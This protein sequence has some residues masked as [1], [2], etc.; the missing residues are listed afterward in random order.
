MIDYL[1]A[2]T[3]MVDCQLR[4]NGVTDLAV[5]EAF[6]TVPREEFVPSRS[7]ALSYTDEDIAVQP[8][9]TG[10]SAR[11]LMAPMALA[12]LISL[13]GIE[14]DD[15]VLDIG[16]ASGYSTALLSLLCN[17]V[18]A[19]ECDEDLA[20][21]AGEKLTELNYDNAVV[22]SGALEDG[23][24]SEG[25]YDI[26]FI[27]GAVDRVPEALFSQLKDGGRLAV[28]EGVGNAGVARLYTKN[29]DIASGR[30]GF[31]CAVKP[32][33]GFQVAEEFVL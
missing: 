9:S 21:Q 28:V 33:P 2:R 8:D 4:P 31:N 16:C 18:V 13:A 6:S 15:I 32:L 3:T 17:S 26:I 12:K 25:P 14:K 23:Y 27:G 10:H 30:S 24:A 29:G 7:R 19:L 1:Q 11:Y 22:V 5:L 20:R